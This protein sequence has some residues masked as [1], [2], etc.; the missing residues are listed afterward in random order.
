MVGGVVLLAIALLALLR[1]N[2]LRLKPVAPTL[3]TPPESS[4]NPDA[5][6]TNKD[7]SL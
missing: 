2:D 7:A 1:M 3:E 6:L 5:T 4:A